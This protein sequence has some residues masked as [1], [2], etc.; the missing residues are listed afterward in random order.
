MARFI[1][2]SGI[3]K[4]TVTGVIG[5]WRGLSPLVVGI[6]FIALRAFGTGQ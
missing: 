4:Q 6:L 1:S 3:T 5:Q 2:T